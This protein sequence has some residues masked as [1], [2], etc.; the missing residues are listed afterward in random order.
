MLEL[1]FKEVGRHPLLTRAQEVDL[2]QRIE[3]G[4]DIA[5]QKMITSNLRLAISIARK[6]S[7]N[8]ISLE[9][10]IQ[11]SNIGL[12]KAVERFDWRRG[13]KFSTYACWWIKQAVT[14]HISMNNTTIRIP[15]HTRGNSKQIKIFVES[16]VKE[17]NTQP[18]I[19]EICEFTGLSEVLVKASLGANHLQY[20][21]SLDASISRDGEGRT[22]SEIVPDEN[23]VNV[24]DK[25]DNEKLVEVIK[26]ALSCLTVREEMILR[27]R[28]GIDDAI[29]S[30]MI[31]NVE[32][33]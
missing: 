10:L 19:A 26:K 13:F 6:Y 18:S 5:R 32:E 14:R 31:Y 29:D 2:A 24:D 30:T 25:L 15:G 16:Y 9:D 23:A 17:F 11:E 4:D 21:V 12:M 8:G 33:K 22:V 28:F 3:K 27:L 7:N 1:Y 20:L